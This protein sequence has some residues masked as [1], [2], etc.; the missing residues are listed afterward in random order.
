MCNLFFLSILITQSQWDALGAERMSEP[1]NLSDKV[2]NLE[3]HSDKKAL[4]VSRKSKKRLWWGL[5]IFLFIVIWI[6]YNATKPMEVKTIA[7]LKVAPP[8]MG[9]EILT[10]SGYIIPAHKIELSPKITGRVKWIGVN[11][12]DFVKKGQEIIRLE[13]VEFQAMHTEAQARLSAA[14]EKLNELKTGS[15]KEEIKIAMA[16]KQEAETNLANSQ[17]NYRRMDKLFKEGAVS[18]ESYDNAS[19]QLEVARHTLESAKENYQ[20]VLTGPRTEQV[21]QA[22]A[23]VKAAGASVT[24]SGSQL[25]DTLIKAPQDGTILEKLIE[26]G[27]IVTPTSYGGTRGARTA[28]LTMANLKDLQVEIDLNENDIPKVHL[29]QPTEVTLEAYPDKKYQ[30]KVVE[31]A[32]EANRQKATIQI[33]IQILD[34]D[35]NIRTEMNAKVSFLNDKTP[36]ETGAASHIYVPAQAISKDS[37]A[38]LSWVYIIENNKAKKTAITPGKETEMG[39]DILEGLRGDE[40]VILPPL[41]KLKAGTKV[42]ARKL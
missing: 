21:Q 16:K 26:P 19:T 33:K 37:A 30:G 9:Q 29:N 18:R 20:M 13:D 34:P 15:R 40:I 17:A 32:P 23:D 12:G 22:A 4:T 39:V 7:A 5:A 25:S 6:G 11:K 41:D 35:A 36:A 24:Y 14:Q 2:K 3:I 31:I 10:A 8:K 1:Q 27:E 28:F 38:N 42:K